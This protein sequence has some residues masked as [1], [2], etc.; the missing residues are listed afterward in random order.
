MNLYFQEVGCQM[1][2]I[3]SKY[4]QDWISLGGKLSKIDKRCIF[5]NDLKTLLLHPNLKSFI[6]KWQ[7]T[8]LL[9]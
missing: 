4:N 6:S 5:Y 9:P 8:E 7:Q 3:L 2:S 1:G